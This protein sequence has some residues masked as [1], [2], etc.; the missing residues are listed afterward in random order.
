MNG[1]NKRSKVFRN[2][3]RDSFLLMKMATTLR[4]MAGVRNAEV[5]QATTPNKGLLSR[6]G[7]LT[8]EIQGATP[9]DLF[10]CIVAEDSEKAHLALEHAEEMLEKGLAVQEKTHISRSLNGALTTLPGAN[11]AL[12]SIPGPYVKK[13]ALKA[14]GKGLNLF[15]FSNNVDP[16]DEIEIKKKAIRQGLLVMGPDCGTAIL[17]GVAL[18]FAN[19][20]RR[21]RVGLVGASGTG[22]Q[23]VSVLLHQLGL[24]ISH[25]LGTGS[26]DV[27]DAVG[28]M[29][30]IQGIEMLEADPS[31]EIIVIVSKPAGQEAKERILHQLHQ[32]R[33][34][35]IANFLGESQESRQEKNIFFTLT[36]EETAL[37]TAQRIQGGPM[38]RVPGGLTELESRKLEEER[39]KFQ[40]GQTYLRGLF[41][42]GT[43]A[44][45]A[46]L[47]L[48][49]TLPSVSGNIS[50]RGIARL[51]DV[52]KS[53]GHA[54]VDLGADELTLGKPHPMLE[55]EMR[56]DRLLAEAN[57]P[58]VGVILM[59]F[60]LGY[61]V[62]PDP[63]GATIPMLKEA[64]NI[65]LVKGRHLAVVASICGTDEDPQN[66]AEQSRCLRENG[67]FLLPSNAQAALTAARLVRP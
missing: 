44:T 38:A 39:G 11:L 47:I 1:M 57:D 40:K 8:E 12:I 13:E 2:T 10:V 41:T 53:A 58:E 51:S 37:K 30:M 18:G 35:V 65:A 15:I 45:E 28:G 25:A 52:R 43:L 24:G 56:R 48:Q 19:R 63:V 55:P 27:S 49:H 4:K 20:V 3:Y 16:A 34:T 66:K 50:L 21:G 26:N 59:D 23:E 36:L 14:L 60:V 33:K 6:V 42:G 17:Q 22:L 29:T 46:A 54:I 67:V 62:H 9:N 61:G 64:R 7:L 5:M 32:C 31:T